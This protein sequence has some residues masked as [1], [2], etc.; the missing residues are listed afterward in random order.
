M[1][2]IL[3]TDRYNGV[4]SV[5]AIPMNLTIHHNLTGDI[6][7]VTLA[8]EIAID[9][10]E[11]PDIMRM[12]QVSPEEWEQL[13]SNPRFIELLR[14]EIEAWHSATNTQER[15]KNKTAAL[16]EMWL[17]EAH[18]RLHDKNEN[19]PAKVELA[20]LLARLANMGMERA[21]INGDGASEKFSV[22]I[23][24]G[25]DKQVRVERDITPQAIYYDEEVV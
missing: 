7:L 2:A 13:Q 12:Y 14:Q 9:N 23:N 6:R 4:N 5:T 17:L 21:N 1:F 8:R 19:L 20:K 10:R 3:H 25:Q 15:V 22:T 16:L 24:I 18:E 11:L